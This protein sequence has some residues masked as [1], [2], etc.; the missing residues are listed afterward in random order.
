MAAHQ[1]RHIDVMPPPIDA[2]PPPID[3]MPPP[4]D[5][6]PPIRPLIMG[7]DSSFAALLAETRNEQ[8]RWDFGSR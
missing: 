5:V 7:Q 3:A 6:L 8:E 2:M 1:T 4:I